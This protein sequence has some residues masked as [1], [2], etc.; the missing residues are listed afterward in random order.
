MPE[1]SLV[2]ILDADQEGFLRSAGSLIQAI[3]RAARNVRGKA[4]LYADT[5]TRSMRAA[6]D[7]TAR[8]RERQLEHNATHGIVP[9]SIVRQVMDVMEGARGDAA[10]GDKR[11]RGRSQRVAEPAENYAALAPAQREAR[12]AQLEQTMYQ[13]ARDLEFEAAAKVR[14]EIRRLREAGLG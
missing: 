6:L 8:R 9:T 3:G 10:P 14:D 13:H 7:E 11:G 5:I 4:I 2:A 12:I 1:V